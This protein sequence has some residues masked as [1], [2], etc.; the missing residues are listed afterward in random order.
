[1]KLNHYKLQK[2][3][4]QFECVKKKQELQKE[5]QT[6][7]NGIDDKTRTVLL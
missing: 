1:M 2:I 5:K 6:E 7:A 4:E 3:N